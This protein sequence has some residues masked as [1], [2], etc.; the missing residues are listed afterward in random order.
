MA[1]VSIL[2][3]LMVILCMGA[4]LR[5]YNCVVRSSSVNSL[6]DGNKRAWLFRQDVV[7]SE[8]QTEDGFEITVLWTDKQ[9][10]QFA[11]L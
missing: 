7:R 3:V 11:G 10:A 1:N 8:E 6:A 5:P 4:A 9:A 2:K